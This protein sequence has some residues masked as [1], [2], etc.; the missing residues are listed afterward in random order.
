MFLILAT[1]IA[2][3][4][5]YGSL[6]GDAVIIIANSVSL[7]LLSGI[8]SFKLRERYGAAP[9]AIRANLR[10]RNLNAA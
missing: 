4:I 9:S 3:W 5:T 10:V 6:L 1:G 7:C 8:L 2:L